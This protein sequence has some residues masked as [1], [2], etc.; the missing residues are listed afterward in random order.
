MREFFENRLKERQGRGTH[1]LH[2]YRPIYVKFG[3]EYF[4]ITPLRKFD[5]FFNEN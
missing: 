1:T 2:I 5:F 3:I 4:D